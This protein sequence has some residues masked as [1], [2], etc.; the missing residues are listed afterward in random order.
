MQLT[1][2]NWHSHEPILL[3]VCSCTCR[4]G[5]LG[6]EKVVCVHILPVLFQIGQ[7]MFM[8][9][10]EHILVE[11]S[12]AFAG[13]YCND[14]E[15]SKQELL[16]SHTILCQSDYGSLPDKDSTVI[17]I[18]HEYSVGTERTKSKILSVLK[19]TAAHVEH[20]PL[21]DINFKSVLKM[22]RTKE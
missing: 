14:N 6:I 12:N 19:V 16:M 8:G 18:L 17:S 7:L 1:M 2:L 11:S 9:M 3:H 5:S 10:S 21:R 4:C 22:L 13:N 15:E 20:G